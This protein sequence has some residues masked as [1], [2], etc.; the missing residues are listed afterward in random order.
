M[1]AFLLIIQN[2]QKLITSFGPYGRFTDNS[3]RSAVNPK[4]KLDSS[5]DLAFIISLLI[6]N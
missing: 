1:F 2:T 5:V 3:M 6:F 4:R